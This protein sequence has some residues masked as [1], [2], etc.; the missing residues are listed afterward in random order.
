[1]IPNELIQFA[2]LI[3]SIGVI[4]IGIAGILWFLTLIAEE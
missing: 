4:G 2:A 1:M 3:L